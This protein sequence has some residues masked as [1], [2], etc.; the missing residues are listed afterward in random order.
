MSPQAFKDPPPGVP[1]AG[2]S[3][4]PFEKWVWTDLLAFDIGQEDGGVSAY[5]ETLGFVPHGLSLLISSPDFI[6]LHDAMAEDQELSPAFCSRNGHEGNET[7]RRQVWTRHLLRRLVE[8]LRAAGCRV[9]LSNFTGYMEDRFHREWLSDHPECL[10]TWA[11]Y[12]RREALFVL[13]RMADGRLF[14]EFFAR[15][16]VRVCE[17][18]G[19]D[20]WHGPDGYGPSSA[21]YEA[22]YSDDL[23]GQF[24]EMGDWRLPPE[25]T[26]PS[27]DRP[28]ALTQRRDW[29]WR[30][31]RMEWL[32]FWTERWAGFWKAVAEALHGIGRKTMI[33]S[34][35][36]RDPFEAIY[37]YG[38]D[39]RKIVEA[40]V[41]AIMVE[42]AAG[43]ILVGSEDRDYHYDFL[44]MLLHFSACVP[45]TPLIFLHNTKDVVE[46]WDL[47]RH[48]PPMLE[49]EVYALSNVFYAEEGGQPRRC[50]D[51]FLACLGDGISAAE[52]QWLGRQWR[53]AFSDQPRRVHGATLV[54]ADSILDGQLAAFACTRDASSH[55]LT[56]A[57]MERN[58]PIQIAAPVRTAIGMEGVLLLLNAHHL[59]AAERCALLESGKALV[60]IG[61]DF[62]EWPQPDA[63]WVDTVPGRPLRCRL[64]GATARFPAL[65]ADG[66]ESEFPDDPLAL[67][68]P[69][70]FREIPYF[71][72]VSDAFLIGCAAVIREI[73]GAFELEP[74]IAQ[75]LA[76]QPPL[77]AGVMM[78]ESRPGHYRI[79]VKNSATVYG[80]MK[81]T[82]GCE[83]RSVQV[84]SDFPVTPVV[85]E[86][87]SFSLIVPQR[88]IVVARVET[89]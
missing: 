83:V 34:A 9:Y 64:Y 18:Y 5:L 35:W 6:L 20:G 86:G 46:N 43:G 59:S 29:I 78:T 21:V 55:W 50:V 65:P 79:A 32:H 1:D 62:S 48:A 11:S 15:Q 69:I 51:G 13:T 87:K 2:V 28:E 17:D 27:G 77:K 52:W 22:D 76:T 38:V 39:Y 72:P 85:P 57:L 71:R 41:D 89:K 31:L 58:A 37:R 66:A 44:A 63:E 73:S 88:G 74:S 61:P 49:R 33:N 26:A 75:N 3:A 68:E 30:H 8:T 25:L 56:Y 36:T 47:L 54:W 12:G 40:G 60:A 81:L 23:L 80:R 19:F 70:R 84:L 16:L 14:Q 45:S 82:L 7:R 42:T 24:M 4:D 10:I 53:L 67:T